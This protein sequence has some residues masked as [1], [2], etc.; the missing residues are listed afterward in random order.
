MLDA[1]GRL[2]YRLRL[3]DPLLGMEASSHDSGAVTCLT[4]KTHEVDIEVLVPD[5]DP[6]PRSRSSRSLSPW[7]L[8]P[9]R[10]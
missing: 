4:Y 6:A 8:G 3:M 1:D 10:A 5:G 7:R 9:Q 2:R